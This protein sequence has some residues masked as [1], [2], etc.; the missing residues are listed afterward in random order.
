MDVGIIHFFIFAQAIASGVLYS[1]T[2]LARASLLWN[3][4]LEKCQ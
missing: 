3:V 2:A 4:L 1:Q